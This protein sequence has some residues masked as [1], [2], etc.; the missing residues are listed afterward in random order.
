M[1]EENED[2]DSKRCMYPMSI[3][4]FL[5]KAKIEKQPVHT[6]THTHTHTLTVEYYSAIENEI[7][8]FAIA[9]MDLEAIMFSEIGQRMTKLLYHLYGE[10]KK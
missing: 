8:P 4:A 2:S 3:A 6:H 9:W 10:C 1:S 5:R 7:L